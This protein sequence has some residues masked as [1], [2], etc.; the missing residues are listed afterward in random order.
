M[1]IPPD[2]HSDNRGNPPVLPEDRYNTRYR[3]FQ[4]QD[5]MAN[6]VATINPPTLTPINIEPIVLP[7][8]DDW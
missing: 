5:I 7:E 6:H 1:N 8:G 3:R 2:V 4:V